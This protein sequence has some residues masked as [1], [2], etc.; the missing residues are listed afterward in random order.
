[1]K[2]TNEDGW[3]NVLTGVGS[4]RDKTMKASC[5]WRQ[6][7]EAECEAMLAGDDMAGKI[8]RLIP[9]DATRAGIEFSF[10]D[11][12]GELVEEFLKEEYERL[13][14][15]SKINEAYTL[16]RAFGCAVIFMSL[17]DGRELDQEVDLELVRKINA[18]Q[19]FDKTELS[20]MQD[21]IDTDLTSPTFGQPLYY[22]YTTSIVGGNEHQIR[23][24]R[25]RLLVFHG[26]ILPH[27]LFQ[28]NGFFHDSIF[29]KMK[30]AIS[31]YSVSLDGIATIVQEFNQPVFMLEGLNEALAMDNNKLVIDRINIANECRSSLRAMV[32]DKNDNFQ[33][34]T[35]QV[36]GLKDLIVLEKERLTAASDIPH[37]RLQGESP[38]AS[39]GEA[40]RS[41]LNDYYDTVSARQEQFIRPVINKINELMFNQTMNPIEQPENM[42]FEFKPLYQEDQKTIIET[43]NIQADIDSKYISAGVYDAIEV[44]QSRFMGSDYSFNTVLDDS[45]EREIEA[46]Q[47]PIEEQEEERTFERPS[48]PEEQP[49]ESDEDEKK[50]EEPEEENKP[51][52]SN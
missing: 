21:D 8:A 49:E 45:I 9:Y 41:E 40:G 24:H 15:W 38:A 2:Q 12:N 29:N 43:R 36:G 17:D 19:V 32:L 37:T 39:L 11:S 44:A 50:E 34:A 31:N 18:L 1:M 42:S 46:I 48:R 52:A 35:S 26:D 47:P 5:Q 25:S 13:S 6:I 27:R 10:D 20:V 33:F 4:R 23:I 22:R 28:N 51:K 7:T 3:S 16:A 14:V 30:K